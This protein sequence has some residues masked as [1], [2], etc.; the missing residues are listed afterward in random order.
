MR[1]AT[2]IAGP[3]RGRPLT[4]IRSLLLSVVVL[5][6]ALAGARTPLHHRGPR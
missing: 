1:Y 5:G 6:A 2:L 4:T 3:L